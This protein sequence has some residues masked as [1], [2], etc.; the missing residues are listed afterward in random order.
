MIVSITLSNIKIP[1]ILLM[2]T[3]SLTYYSTSLY[4]YYNTS[5]LADMTGM[6]VRIYLFDRMIALIAL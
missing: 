4:P 5:T 6:I 2:L 1:D 3:F